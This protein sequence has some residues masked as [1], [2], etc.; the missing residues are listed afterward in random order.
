MAIDKD[1]LW[2]KDAIIYQTHIKAFFDS[3]DDGV[4]DFEGLIRKLDYIQDLGVNTIWLLPF[5]P[6]PLRDD[7]YDIQD[8]RSINPAYGSMRD[9]KRLIREAHRRGLRLITELVI[10]H[11]S[12]QHAWFQ[13][14]RH[15]RPGSRWRD[16]Y[17]W[18]DT[19]QKYKDTRIIFLD[20]EVSNWTWD[21]VA[22]AYY[23]H[24]FYSHQ[25]DLNFDNPAVVKEIINLL[26]YWMSLGI[27]GLRLD[28]IPYLI[29]REGTNCENLPETHD[30]LKRI[31]AEID[32]HFPGRMLLAEAN[33]WPEDTRP[34]FGDGDECHMAFH[35]P[36][37][38][39]MY[40]AVA[41]EDRHPITDIMRQTPEI[42]ENCQWAIFLRNHDELTLEMVTENERE[43]LWNR[44]ATDRRMRINL[45]IRRRLAPLMD[46]DRRKIE[47]M[48]SLLLSM[49]GTPVIY[50]GD[51]IGMGENIYLGDRDGVRTPMQWS[52]DRN[53]G[54][55]RANPQQLYLPAVMDPVYGFQS[56]NVEAQAR[57]PSSLLNWMK[58]LIVTRRQHQA[59]SRGTLN[60]TYPGN[61][62]ILAYTRET[63]DEAI[64]CVVNL[65]RHAQPVELDLHAW[66]G[67]V[68]VELLGRTVF[69]PVSDVPYM[70]TL[71]G[72]GF[73]W[74]LLA[75]EAEVPSW[76]APVP[77][78]L[79]EFTTLVIPQGWRSLMEDRTRRE[80]EQR[81]LPSF[82]RTQRWFAA[83]DAAVQAV[84]L[85]RHAVIE[86]KG[87]DSFLLAELEVE[88]DGREKQAYHLPLAIGW[89][90]E[91]MAHGAPLL[92]FTLAR[93][94]RAQKIGA[95]YDATAGEGLARALL[96]GMR[97]G[98]VLPASHGELRFSSGE[99]IGGFSL[100][101]DA[102]TRRLGVEQS[103]TSLMVGREV[104]VKVYRRLQPGV[105]P[106]IEIARFLTDVAHFE[107]TPPL[108]GSL[109]RIDASGEPTALAA[110]YGFVLS[111]GDGWSFTLGYLERE[112]ETI[113]LAATATTAAED[114]TGT[115]VPPLETEFS[116]YRNYAA[117]LGQRTADMH[118][119][120]AIETD[121]PAFAHEPVDEADLAVLAEGAERQAQ[122][123]FKVLARVLP[124]LDAE[125]ASLA[126]KVQDAQ[127]QILE[128]IRAFAGTALKA[129][130][131]RV[132]GD[133]HLGQV[134]VARDDFYILDF[135]GEPARPIAERRA[136]T[137][138]FKD[139]A[140]MLRSF[141]YAAWTVAEQVVDRLAGREALI[142]HACLVWRR[143]ACRAFLDAYAAGT[144]DN[145]A[146][147]VDGEAA[148]ALLR[149][150][151]MEK[152]L[153]EVCYEAA[154]RPRWLKIPLGGL[155]ELLD[156]A[157]NAHWF[158]HDTATD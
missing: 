58:A 110:A 124:D 153:Y 46:N 57:N 91:Q 97:K 62:K 54:F 12:D 3:N 52:V 128:R 35:F 85:A 19:A 145:P 104:I 70:L 140:G 27:D 89:G 73:Y 29:E 120:L 4:G 42:P 148:E 142:R 34:Y 45:G 141:D 102:E 43:Y 87:G 77:D 31:R 127:G 36:L 109:E 103:N 119:A 18:S 50:Y 74:F 131:I 80:L 135:E 99:R 144:S 133:Y 25:P 44:Y 64:L 95:L 94:R 22:K 63:E 10:N 66:R 5:Y 78:T 134:L 37:M 115:P 38:P 30:I 55:S 83:K 69:P 112:I 122:E 17:V 9:V 107:N 13:R 71:P 121:D 90:E 125:S 67:R 20:T 24:R 33:Q 123:A 106:E 156:E 76:H 59:F 126:H 138:P 8:Y 16:Y 1:P 68:P 139:V 96:D 143:L 84:R 111:Q 47:L 7:G 146:V 108:L 105:H 26:H 129:S 28:A 23:W 79:P 60:F 32:S 65:S 72:H 11:T 41:Q 39:R 152:A 137:S 116:V 48:N 88:L 6:S 82:A 136:K 130:K 75:K 93:V 132:H 155:V 15:A 113:G 81:A 100:P 53:G 149:L 158:R 150:F 21:P 86:G 101:L 2:Y 51:E 92:P 154:N 117:K 147:P 56:V 40:L 61:R 14:A 157:T 49:P 151:I 98:S 114:G 118:N